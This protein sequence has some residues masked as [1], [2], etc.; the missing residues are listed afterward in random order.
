MRSSTSSTRS[1]SMTKR[2]PP[3][4]STRASELTRNCRVRWLNGTPFLS[5]ERGD[6]E[7]AVNPAHCPL[8]HPT[9]FQG[10]KQRR[11]IR[12]GHRPEAAVAATPYRRAEGTAAGVRDRAQAGRP[13]R[14]HHARQAAPLALGADAR[15]RDVRLAAGEVGGEDFEQ[16]IAIDR[17]AT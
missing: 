17:A 5:G 12:V 10:R 3:S 13:V 14:D 1:P 16:L 8:V 9:S 2:S 7:G 6:V 11:K 15:V 4:P